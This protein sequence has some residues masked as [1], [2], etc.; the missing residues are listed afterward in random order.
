MILGIYEPA[1]GTKRANKKQKEKQGGSG[2]GGKQS[3]QD[4]ALPSTADPQQQPNSQ[5]VPS[6]SDEPIYN[7]KSIYGRAPSQCS[8][9]SATQSFDMRMY[10]RVQPPQT[11]QQ[12]QQLIQQQLQQK[13]TGP[14]FGTLQKNEKLENPYYY[15][16]STRNQKKAKQQVRGINKW[17][18]GNFE[19]FLPPPF[20]CIFYHGL[21]QSLNNKKCPR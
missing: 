9:I 11:I 6:E 14:V 15:Y 12:Q 20:C 10:G 5:M 3:K 21:S 16:G 17:R 13:P 1:P 8:S 2:S 7:G 4:A 18:D 19:I